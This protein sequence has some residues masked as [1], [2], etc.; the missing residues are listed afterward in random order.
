MNALEL[1]TTQHDE[2]EDLF[3]QIEKSK[4]GRM[5]AELFMDLADKLAAHAKIEE[6]IFY[7]AV[8]SRQTED[9]LLES[10]EEHLSIKRVL[11]D[12]LM[13]DSDD[14]H[15]DAKLAVMKEQVEHHAREEEEGELFPKV[16]KLLDAEELEALGSEM[17]SA[18][19]EL[20]GT[21]PR[22]SVPR[23]TEAAASLR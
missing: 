23:E 20:M 1:L 12:L 14:D 6:T 8:M 3:D 22:A 19:E 5:T 13:L 2:V 16:R 4:S 7:P 10:A 18:F 21:Q 15:F 17:L 11:A 9:L